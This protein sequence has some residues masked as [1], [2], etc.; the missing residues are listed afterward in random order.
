MTSQ[1]D[2]DRNVCHESSQH[3]IESSQGEAVVEEG[4]I[5]CG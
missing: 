4:D 1:D 5:K 2:V 3:M